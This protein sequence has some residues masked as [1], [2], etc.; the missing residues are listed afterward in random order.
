M[1]RTQAYLL[2]LCTTLPGTLAAQDAFDIV[3]L[4]LGMTEDEVMAAL[5][6]YNPDMNYTIVE[7]Y[8]SY[9]DGVEYFQTENFLAEIHAGLP[10]SGSPTAEFI[11]SFTPP[12]EGGKVW[13][14]DREE[15]ILSN[16][17][18]FAQYTQAL[19]QKYGEPTATSR[20]GAALV[21]DFPAGSSGCLR[22]PNDPAFPYFR[23][24]HDQDLD[25]RLTFLQRS[26]SVPSDL[27]QCANQLNYTLGTISGSVVDTFNAIL[28]DVPA[29]IRTSE[30]AS[31]V[32]KA[33]EEEAIRKRE[34]AA[35]TPRL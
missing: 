18:S 16:Q 20:Q 28:I 3:G 17:P 26:G 22:D 13:A 10:G 30:A 23:P 6:A 33:L 4:R 14:I 27:S 12:P 29:Y 1:T 25:F 5:E 7:S 2:A 11:I 8:Y 34:G 24:R 31:E 21:W 32:V 9:S 19:V 35:Q 15:K